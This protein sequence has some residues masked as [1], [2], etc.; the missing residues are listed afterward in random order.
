MWMQEHSET[1]MLCFLDI[2]LYAM[3]HFNSTIQD[4]FKLHGKTHITIT[5]I[6]N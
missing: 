5:I 4:F 6:K 1:V 3:V 2:C